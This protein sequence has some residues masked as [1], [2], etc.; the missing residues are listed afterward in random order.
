MLPDSEEMFERSNRWNSCTISGFLKLCCRIV[1]KN[2]VFM[3]ISGSWWEDKAFLNTAG[4]IWILILMKRAEF[5][6]YTHLS[7]IKCKWTTQISVHP[8]ASNQQPVNQNQH[9]ILILIAYFL[10]SL[11]GSVVFLS[12]AVS[13]CPWSV[14]AHDFCLVPA[15]F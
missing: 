12:C 11:I 5:H 13:F 1:M 9:K 3:Y 4:L 6:L 15:E 10:S 2:M 7:D 14:T 8:A